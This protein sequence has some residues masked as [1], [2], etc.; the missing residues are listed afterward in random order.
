MTSFNEITAIEDDAERRRQLIVRGWKLQ[1]AEAENDE[2]RKFCDWM[3][4][5]ALSGVQYSSRPNRSAVLR[6][7]QRDNVE[8]SRV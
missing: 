6:E 8:S 4:K 3:V 2:Q 1:R 7:R 5:C